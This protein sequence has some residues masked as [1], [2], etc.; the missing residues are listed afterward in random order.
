MD[1]NDPSIRADL[2][3]DD[4]LRTDGLYASK[5]PVDYG[6]FLS[7]SYLR[8]YADGTVIESTV[9]GERTNEIMSWFNKTNRRVAK[10]HYSL[11]GTSIEFSVRSEAGVV[12]YWGEVAGEELHLEFLSQINGNRGDDEYS[13]IPSN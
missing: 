11:S 5:F 9:H 4:V 12:N 8:F 1:A 3:E 6:A 2:L 7:F 13:F 10:G